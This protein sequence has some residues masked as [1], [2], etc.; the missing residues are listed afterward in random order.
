ML[1]AQRDA[2]SRDIVDSIFGCGFVP[3]IEQAQIEQGPSKSKKIEAEGLGKVPFSNMHLVVDSENGAE[4]EDDVAPVIKN[5]STIRLRNAERSNNIGRPKNSR[6][7]NSGM[8]LVVDSENGAEPEDDVAPVIKNKSTIRLRNAERSNNIGRPKNSRPKNSGMHLVVDS[9]KGRTTRGRSKRSSKKK[10]SVAP[11]TSEEEFGE[12]SLREPPVVPAIGNKTD[13]SDPANFA[14][15]PPDELY[16]QL[17][18]Q[19]RQLG[20]SEKQQQ[21]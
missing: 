4:P 6:P 5:K 13:F 16:G 19:E 3:V 11:R 9:E 8:H 2:K 18:G 1:E 20:K 21:H 14:T 15:G 10:A 12:E 7:K 17:F